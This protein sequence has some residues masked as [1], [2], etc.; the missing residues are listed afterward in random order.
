MTRSDMQT[1]SDVDNH[2]LGIDAIAQHPFDTIFE[3][4]PGTGTGRTGSLETA[5]DL[6]VLDLD[7]FQIAAIALQHR[8]DD[9]EY[10][11]LDFLVELVGRLLGGARPRA[12]PCLVLAPEL[13]EQIL[14]P[15]C[16]ELAAST[17]AAGLERIAD[18]FDRPQVHFLDLLAQVG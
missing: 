16:L 12:D 11:L 6:L 17:S 18:F 7:D 2:D 8:P 9:L 5:I 13:V 1:S 14:D 4:N 3:R 10:G 15:T